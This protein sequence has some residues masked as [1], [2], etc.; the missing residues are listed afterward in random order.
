MACTDSLPD[1]GFLRD[2]QV[3][4][5]LGISRSTWWRWVAEGWAPAAIKLGPQVAAWRVEDIRS[6]VDE[7][8][9]GQKK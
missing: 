5:H 3:A 8:R 2:K 9:G 7:R 4:T 6:F 1:S